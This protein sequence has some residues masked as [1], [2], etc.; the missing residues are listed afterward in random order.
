MA[1]VVSV[2]CNPGSGMDYRIETDDGG[3]I[4][5]T[6]NFRDSF[7]ELLIAV[8]DA[9]RGQRGFV[10]FTD[11]P[12]STRLMLEP[13]DDRVELTLMA[14]DDWPILPS[15]V[16]DPV[17]ALDVRLRTFAGAVL[18]A[19]QRLSED[20]QAYEQGSRYEFPGQRL[21]DLAATLKA[22]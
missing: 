6:E 22:T 4:W 17:G 15:A 2:T 21:T 3:L 16:G 18:S 9:L 19:G 13:C 11:L 8:A 10:E 1:L 5:Q 14:F 20:R 12:R 7:R